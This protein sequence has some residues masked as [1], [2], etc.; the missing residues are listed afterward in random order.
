[1]LNWI[2]ALRREDRAQDLVEYTLLIGFVALAVVGVFSG[3]GGSIGGIWGSAN[4][5]LAAA[6]STATPQSPGNGDQGGG[7][8]GGGDH[9]DKDHGGHGDRDGD[10]H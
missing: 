6:N 3:A 7:S 2:R 10:G 8:G 4:T 9:G 1:M 5:T